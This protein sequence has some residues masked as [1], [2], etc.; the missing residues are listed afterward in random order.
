M[1]RI[2][3]FRKILWGRISK[4]LNILKKLYIQTNASSFLFK[5]RKRKKKGTLA[6]QQDEIL[7]T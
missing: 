2:E 3:K 1:R 7:L 4:S 5:K 6:E